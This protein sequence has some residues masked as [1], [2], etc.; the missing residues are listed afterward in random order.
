ME[1]VEVFLP[2]VV[3]WLYVIALLQLTIQL[4]IQALFVTQ[5]E[6][7]LELILETP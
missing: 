3:L 4:S 6:V 1:L 5:V 2:L 7:A